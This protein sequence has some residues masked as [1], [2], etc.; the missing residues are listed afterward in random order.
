MTPTITTGFHPCV[1]TC[2]VCDYGS[3]FTG[4]LSCPVCHV[5]PTK[6]VI[7]EKATDEKMELLGDYDQWRIQD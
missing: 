3:F 5:A 7:P 2:V 1:Y 4:N 6:P